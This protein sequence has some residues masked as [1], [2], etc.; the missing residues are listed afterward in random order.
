ML[1]PL[2]ITLIDL[3]FNDDIVIAIRFGIVALIV[4][5]CL[6]STPSQID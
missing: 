1:L 4:G 6:L 5:S 3:I 2:I